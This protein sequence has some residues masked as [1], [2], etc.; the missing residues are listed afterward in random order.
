MR[1]K[2]KAARHYRAGRRS[3][4]N[5]FAEDISC[6]AV[7]AITLLEIAEVGGDAEENDR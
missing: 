2:R 1:S 6:D 4:L 5:A 3:A 7:D